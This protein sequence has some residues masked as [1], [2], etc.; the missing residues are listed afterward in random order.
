MANETSTILGR[1]WRGER[2]QIYGSV[3]IMA[4]SERFGLT[5][6]SQGVHSSLLQ[7]FVYLQLLDFLTTWVG[8]RMGAGELNP[9]TAWLMD[10]SSPLVGLAASKL[11][12]M[13]LCAVCILSGRFR[14]IRY[15]IYFFA[16]LVAWNLYHILLLTA[17]IGG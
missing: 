5:L 1:V 14:V 6:V 2:Y 11:I 17:M 15:A 7:A 13:A 4:S 9:F 8:L 12:G 16:F 10:L 3:P